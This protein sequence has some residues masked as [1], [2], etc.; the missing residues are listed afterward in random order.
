MDNPHDRLKDLTDLR[1]LL[2]LYEADTDR[3]FSDE[4]FA[5]ELADITL[6][7]AFLLG[8]DLKLLVSERERLLVEQFLRLISD[9]AKREFSAFVRAASLSSA[10]D[11]D[12]ARRK[13]AAFSAGFEWSDNQA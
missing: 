1:E 2:T 8:L 11:D 10:R 9:E 12:R 5:A 7:S 3:V 6:A 13:L 4:V